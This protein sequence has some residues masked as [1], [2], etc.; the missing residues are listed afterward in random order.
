LGSAL[1]DIRTSGAAHTHLQKNKGRFGSIGSRL[2]RALRVGISRDQQEVERYQ[3][4]VLFIHGIGG[5]KQGETLMSF[6]D[7]FYRYIEQWLS[8]G[9]QEDREHRLRERWSLIEG[10]RRKRQKRGRPS[11]SNEIGA[12][13]STLERKTVRSGSITLRGTSLRGSELEDLASGREIDRLAPDIVTRGQPA[14]QLVEIRLRTTDGLDSVGSGTTWCLAESWWADEFIA[15]DLKSFSRW[16]LLIAPAVITSQFLTDFWRSLHTDLRRIRYWWRLVIHFLLIFAGPPLA[17]LAILGLILMRVL[18]SLPIP[19]LSGAVKSFGVRLSTS[20][21]DSFALV[22]SPAGFDAMLTAINRDLAWLALRCQSVAI[23]A[24][25][26]GAVLAHHALRRHRPLNLKLFITCGSGLGKVHDIQRLRKLPGEAWTS[27]FISLMSLVTVAGLVSILFPGVEIAPV[28]G[29]LLLATSY[30]WIP[31]LLLTA[32][33]SGERVLSHARKE[34]ELYI[35]GMGDLASGFEWIDFYTASD[36]VPNGPIFNRAPPWLKSRRLWSKC[37]VFRDHSSYR[38]NVHGF[39]APLFQEL[40]KLSGT[41]APLVEEH[42]LNLRANLARS[43]WRAGWLLGARVSALGFTLTIVYAYWS[44]MTSMG[45]AILRKDTLLERP[46]RRIGSGL[47]DIWNALGLHDTVVVRVLL[48]LLLFFACYLPLLTL[49]QRWEHRD[50][51]RAFRREA[52]DAG[53]LPGELFIL[54]TCLLPAASIVILKSREAAA[55]WSPV[56]EPMYTAIG[57]SFLPLMIYFFFEVFK[58]GFDGPKTFDDFVMTQTFI[59]D[60]WSSFL[61]VCFLTVALTAVLQFSSL[62]NFVSVGAA[63]IAAALLV[64]LLYGPLNREITTRSCRLPE[65]DEV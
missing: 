3:L 42:G 10:K 58:T 43:R 12:S 50:I 44:S 35:T 23:V 1:A 24:H 46:M 8:L 65:A 32:L 63:T 34:K 54:L 30:L 20:L 62:S 6:G 18:A 15:P 64:K 38:E 51:V 16:A 41:L 29:W 57:W 53:G 49:W 21:G 47:Q 26:Q 39:L 52:M 37:S 13:D 61:Y 14:H 60:M 59:K 5:Q 9:D 22:E 40:A 17:V 7:P 33:S 31:L 2:G 19:K 11:L 48:I 36:P 56:L 55:S 45:E 4:G 27:W 25:S 28:D